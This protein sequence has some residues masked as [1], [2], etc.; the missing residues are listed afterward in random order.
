MQLMFRRLCMAVTTNWSSRSQRLSYTF[1]LAKSFTL[2]RS[3]RRI[4]A[5]RRK[6]VEGSWC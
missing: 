6:H 1:R 3:L 2:T 4:A 5:W